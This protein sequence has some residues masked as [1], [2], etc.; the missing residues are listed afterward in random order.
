MPDTIKHHPYYGAP[1]T[2]T[3]KTYYDAIFWKR[4]TSRLPEYGD[5][6]IIPLRNGKRPNS[7]VHPC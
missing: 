2:Y 7:V 1:Q 6:K 3:N 5:K 4:Q